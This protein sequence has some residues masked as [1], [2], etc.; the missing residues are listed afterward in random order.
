[1]AP[2]LSHLLTTS[3]IPSTST[4][5]TL[6]SQLETKNSEQLTKLEETLSDAETNLGETEISDALKAK[7]LYL[8]RIGDKVR[9][10]VR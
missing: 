6:L 2:Y 7:A 8:A 5:T 9:F 3:Q 4:S 10:V 1:M